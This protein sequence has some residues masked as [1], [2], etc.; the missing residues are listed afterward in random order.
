MLAA[1]VTNVLGDLALSVPS[2][3]MIRLNWGQCHESSVAEFPGACGRQDRLRFPEVNAKTC[4]GEAS[5]LGC[6][7]V[8]LG[9]GWGSHHPGPLSPCRPQSLH[10]G[11]QSPT[12][13]LGPAPCPRL[14]GL[15]PL[16]GRPHPLASP[17]LP[18]PATLGNHCGVPWSSWGALPPKGPQCPHP[19]S[20]LVS[21]GSRMSQE[22]RNKSLMRIRRLV[23]R[24]GAALDTARAPL[25][26]ALPARWVP[27]AG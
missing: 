12:V 1:K 5:C 9:L 25:A 18:T 4:G 17:A 16:S 21:H 19:R 2:L 23:N 10:S 27:E 14:H 26:S 24:A 6:P 22:D 3:C 7:S 11:P 15:A 13:G 20:G 8:G